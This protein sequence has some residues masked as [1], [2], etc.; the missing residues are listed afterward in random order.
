LSIEIVKHWQVLKGVGE[1]ILFLEGSFGRP[2]SVQ[3]EDPA[4]K[5]N[6]AQGTDKVDVPVDDQYNSTPPKSSK[7]LVLMALLL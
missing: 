3:K 7:N 4:E 5:E 1:L 6:E 2:G